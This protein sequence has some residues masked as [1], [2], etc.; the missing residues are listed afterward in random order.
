MVSWKRRFARSIC[1][2][3]KTTFG[4]VASFC[5]ALFAR[6]RTCGHVDHCPTCVDPPP[7]AADAA[8]RRA[9]NRSRRA[10]GDDWPLGSRWIDVASDRHGLAQLRTGVRSR[11]PATVDA[12][13][14][15]A[16]IN[17]PNAIDEPTDQLPRPLPT[18]A[19]PPSPEEMA[20]N[21]PRFRGPQG[22]GIAASAGAP[23]AWDVATGE[24][25]V[26][27]SPLPLPGNNS[28]IVW[29]DRLFLTGATEAQRV[30]YCFDTQTGD[31][32][33]QSELPAPQKN[34]PPPKVSEETGYAAPTAATDGRRVYVTF[35]SGDVAAFDFDGN[36]I[37]HEA[38]GTPK[39]IY[40]FATSLTTYQNLLIVQFDQGS[41]KDDLSSLIAFD[42]AS[43]EIAWRTPRK[44]PNSWPS[45]IVI[46]HENNPRIIT[47]ADPWVIAY[48]P[49][50]GAEIWRAKCL[51]QDVGPSPIYVD[52]TI[53]VAN[54]FPALSA[55][56]A[57]GEGDVTETHIIWKAEYGLPDTCS[58]VA[59]G[60]LVLVLA[61]FGTLTCYDGA[62]GGEP[63]WE[64]DF[65]DN[66]RSSPTAV[67]E[68]VYL[69]GEEGR[70]W[71][72]RVGRD[73]GQILAEGDLGEPCVTS[74][75]VLGGRIYVRGKEHLYCIGND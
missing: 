10:P 1:R 67:G 3:A 51:R 6:G 47:A 26:W 57:G 49:E 60:P 32:V 37:W 75:A 66:F 61:S 17:P 70:S 64:M 20:Q 36:R 71:V 65:D 11:L 24:K 73:G 63:L 4:I 59:V 40:G 7:Q 27:K 53:F 15:I 19:N 2:F 38:L 44:V 28:P 42:A 22:A 39:N 8:S 55:I 9:A 74:P 18:Q 34:V 31:V 48:N 23:M 25:I 52:G 46:E 72:V 41:A 50:S 58:P 12:P 16:A 68:N 13:D 62:E 54:E 21:W 45:P 35:A 29:N 69:F 30:V 14:Q 43:G 56:R 33:W 5:A